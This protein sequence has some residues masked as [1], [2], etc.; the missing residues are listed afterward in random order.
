M[1][2]VVCEVSEG[3]RKAEAT[4]KLVSYDG[5]PEFLPVDRGLLSAENGSQYLS[6]G[7]LHISPEKKAALISLPVEADSG[8]AS[9]L[10]EAGAPALAGGYPGMILSDREV[11]A[12]IRRKVILV[13]PCPPANDK[14]WSAT[15][16]DLTLDA[17]IRPWETVGGAGADITIEPA[18]PE[19][20]SNELIRRLTKPQSCDREGY[21]VQLRTLVLGWT[22]EQVELPERLADRRPRGGQEQP[23]AH[24]AGHPRH[25]SHHSP[26]LRRKG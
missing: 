16:L 11:R 20:N 24:R 12:A 19:Y 18:S 17:E 13:T 9:S 15:T 26:R 8:R 21:V 14:R 1:A 5:R 25:R 2:Q 23:G 3:L 4:V 22:L 6:V 10:G 7:L